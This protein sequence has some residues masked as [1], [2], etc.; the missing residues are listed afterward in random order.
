[1]KKEMYLYLTAGELKALDKLPLDAYKIYVKLMALC[2]FDSGVVCPNSR[3]G[4]SYTYLASVI[5]ND[6]EAVQA[7][8]ARLSHLVNSERVRYILNKLIDLDLVKKI[9]MGF[10]GA[11]KLVIKKF[12]KTNGLRTNSVQN[13]DEI[14]TSSK[15]NKGGGSSTFRANSVPIPSS[16]NQITSNN[17][18]NN[19]TSSSDSELQN[20]QKTNDDDFLNKKE[21]LAGSG[22]QAVPN[23]ID[24]NITE[25]FD[26]Y[27]ETLNQHAL[28]ID[29]NAIRTI[30][31]ALAGG[32]SIQDLKNAVISLKS[33]NHLLSAGKVGYKYCWSLDIP[34]GLDMSYINKRLQEY[35][36][37]Q[38][39]D[40]KN[41]QVS[42]STLASDSAVPEIKKPTSANFDK[43]KC[44]NHVSA[45]LKTA[46]AL[47]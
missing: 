21:S 1:M 20:F 15:Q 13:T 18:N 16:I 11:L 12:D 19:Q 29:L 30:K 34:R 10:R 23:E 46:K 43:A 27:K 14:S 38:Q 2:D 41:Q 32:Y 9:R 25:V 44:L 35:S 47:A 4:I 7:G 42:I 33:N 39:I 40:A 24:P 36:L 22:S 3:H 26:H 5:N 17:S 37:L 45:L 8:S 28:K 6:R 31:T